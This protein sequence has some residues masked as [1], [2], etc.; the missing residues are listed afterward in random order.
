MEKRSITRTTYLLT[1]VANVETD[2]DSGYRMI[3]VTARDVSA[4]GAYLFAETET[5]PEPGQKVRVL[6]HSAP[7]LKNSTMMFQATGVV[8]RLEKDQAEREP[9]FAV[10]FEDVPNLSKR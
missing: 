10:Q 5:P 3:D 6:L 1:G 8:V 9:G 7:E 4:E 2:D